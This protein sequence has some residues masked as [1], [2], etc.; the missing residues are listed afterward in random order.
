MQF[1]DAH[2]QHALPAILAVL[3]DRSDYDALSLAIETI[4]TDVDVVWFSEGESAVRHL[5]KCSRVAATPTRRWPAIIVF[6][7]DMI[8]AKP[9]AWFQELHGEIASRRMF[10]ALLA[11]AVP[12][13]SRVRAWPREPDELVSKYRQGH[14]YVRT[15]GQALK[16]WL[17]RTE[18]ERL[19]N[20]PNGA[21]ATHT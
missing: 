1:H 16:Y 9:A 17:R 14:E 12:A 19:G 21:L 15:L 2:A 5:R 11:V 13:L 7:A 6:D 3:P 8:T 18:I 4:S 20:R 10:T